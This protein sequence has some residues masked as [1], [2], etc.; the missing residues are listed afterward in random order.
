MGYTF[1]MN[2]PQPT[3]V[4]NGLMSWTAPLIRQAS[5]AKPLLAADGGANALSEIDVTPTFL[6]GDLDSVRPEVRARMATESI[7]NRPDQESCD[8]EKA[9]EFAFGELGLKEL[10]VLGA[11][12]GRIDHTVGN[13]G[14][15][16]KQGRGLSLVFRE[17]E[18]LV[19]AVSGELCLESRAGETW[20]FWSFDPGLRLT[21][22]GLRW[23]LSG[24]RV[25]AGVRPS[26]SNEATGRS[27]GILAEDGVVLI[28]RELRAQA[29][30]R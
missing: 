24:A 5:R 18:A 7:I 22:R 28:Y 27:V 23:P 3:L 2:F 21:L 9:I 14:I 17:P 29:R 11:L 13:L 10:S 15:L 12:G 20:S 25:D 30:E 19:F 1:K 16:A 4:L 26:I 6:I 8:F